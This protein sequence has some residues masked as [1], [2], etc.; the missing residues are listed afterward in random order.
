MVFNGDAD[1][2][3]LCTLA[4]RLAGGSN[5]VSFPLKDKAIYANKRSR[6]VWRVIWRVYTG[7]IIDDQNNSGSPELTVALVTTLR[8]L[9]AI[10]GAQWLHSMEW[11]DASG[12]WRPLKPITLETIKRRGQAETEFMNTPGDP[13]FYRPVQQGVRLYPDSSASRASALKAH[14]KRDIVAFASTSTTA[15]PGWDSILHEG[16]AIGMALDYAKANN[17]PQAGGTLR[18][19]YKT[20]LFAD[21]SDFLDQVAGHYKA[22][23]AEFFPGTMNKGG[24]RYVESFI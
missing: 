24:R 10:A 18:G 8:N 1:D 23:H 12:H 16:L 3:D 15:T 13:I 6:E 7:A 9:Y 21:W 11:L 5:D 4:D 17:L 22:K 19:G 2:Q 20:G 14:F